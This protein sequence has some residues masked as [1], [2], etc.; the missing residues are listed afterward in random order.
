MKSKVSGHSSTIDSA[1]ELVASL[2]A[3]V[4]GFERMALKEIDP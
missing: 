3:G 1:D 4:I 2:T